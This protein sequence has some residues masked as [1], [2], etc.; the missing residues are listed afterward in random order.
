[1]SDASAR[2]TATDLRVLRISSS[3]EWSRAVEDECVLVASE[4][5]V[6]ALS[7][8]ASPA[9]GPSAAAGVFAGVPEADRAGGEPRGVPA[10]T[11]PSSDA[12]S[13]GIVSSSGTV[14][15]PPSSPSFFSFFFL[16]FL[17]LA[18]EDCED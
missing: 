18:G 1:M 7:I 9:G 5:D 13:A 16:C 10:M 12:A 6:R 8:A 3:S 4:L 15:G 2:A 11:S 14:D 17:A